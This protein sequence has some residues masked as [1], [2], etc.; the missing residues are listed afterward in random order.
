MVLLVGKLSVLVLAG[1]KLVFFTVAGMRLCFGFLLETVVIM[2]GCFPYCWAGFL[3]S[4]G[5]FCLSPHPTNEQP[6]CAQVA[7]R[8]HSPGQLTQGIF[9]AIWCQSQDIKLEE[10]G[11]KGVRSGGIS[12]PKSVLHMREP[13]FPEG[14][15]SP[16]TRNSEWIPCF[17]LLACRVGFALSIKHSLSH[18]VNFLSFSI[19]LPHLTRGSEQVSVWSLVARWG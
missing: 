12:L 5:L 18:T 17:A 16:P 19:F 9:Y 10:K 6:G 2:W 7:G 14:S 1:V 13:C 4:Q 15:S 8:G 3:Q 11:G